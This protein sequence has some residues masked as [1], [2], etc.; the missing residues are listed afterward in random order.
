MQG[1]T[2]GASYHPVASHYVLGFLTKTLPKQTGS[3]VITLCT[4]KSNLKIIIRIIFIL[5]I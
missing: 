5:L 1:A 4:E 3:K 2:L